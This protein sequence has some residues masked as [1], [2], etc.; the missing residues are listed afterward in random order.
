MMRTDDEIKIM[1]AW[2]MF[3]QEFNKHIG[4]EDGRI[5]RDYNRAVLDPWD[6]AIAQREAPRPKPAPQTEHLAEALA[7][8]QP[9][10]TGRQS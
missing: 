8:I 6:A 4:P 5:M 2:Q 3:E 1:A 9:S 7:G 10:E